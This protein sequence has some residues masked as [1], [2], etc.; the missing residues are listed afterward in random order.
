MEFENKRVMTVP[1]AAAQELLGLQGQVTEYALAVDDLSRLDDVAAAVRSALGPGYEVHT[2]DQ[3]QPFVR[4]LLR[5]QV[6]IFSVV[7]AVLIVIVLT[8]IINTMLMSVFERVREIGTMLAVG[9]RRWQVLVLFL[10]EAAVIGL[11]GGAGGAILGRV[12]VALIAV[13]GVQLPIS[14]GALLRPEI[15][16][17]FVALAV[18]LAVLGALGAALYPAYRASRLNPVD[19]LRSL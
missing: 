13:K 5:R 10:F 8:G 1:L 4:D 2:W 14:K 9:V 6:V 18:I 12:G 17:S 15:Q 7:G 11:M 16:P 19:A 3:L